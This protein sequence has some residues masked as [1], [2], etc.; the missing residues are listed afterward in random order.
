MD[1]TAQLVSW[2]NPEGQVTNSDLELLGSVLHHG[3]MADCFDIREWTTLPLTE[4]MTG[5]WWKSKGSAISTSPPACLLH[6][7]A[8]HQR[9]YRYVP[10]H[11]FVIRVD[12]GIS[13]SPYR[14]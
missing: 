7:Q 4:N 12:N 13:N 14:S 5:I 8:I 10:R 6:L 9:L 1:I 11:N 3:C 2:G